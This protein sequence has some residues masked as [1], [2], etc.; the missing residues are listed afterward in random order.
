ATDD[1]TH[2]TDVSLRQGD[3]YRDKLDD[4]DLAIHCFE[5]VMQHEV[6]VIPALVALEPLY[7]S[8]EAWQKLADVY[9]MMGSKLASSGARI[10]ALRELARLREGKQLGSVRDRI[11]TYEAI[12]SI[13]RDD[14][15]AL[16]KVELLARTMQDDALL[17]EV[18]RRLAQLADSAIVSACYLTD[19]GQALERQGD[20]RAL[21]AYRDAVKKDASLLTAIRGLA[22][23][24]DLLN[25]PR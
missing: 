19:L 4:P 7:R 24:G 12:L 2:A 17:I 16:A 11:R 15:T 14:E 10:A 21:D 8:R 5:A 20:R 3:I 13:D 23:V 25:N 22:R 18:Y 1:P 9:A 6:G